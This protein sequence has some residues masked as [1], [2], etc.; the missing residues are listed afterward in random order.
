MRQEARAKLILQSM[1]A[2]KYDGMVVGERDLSLGLPFLLDAAKEAKVP[3]LSANLVDPG[4]K[5]LFTG[6]LAFQDGSLKV[7]VVALSPAGSYGATLT[8]QDPAQA[9]Q[10]ELQAVAGEGCAVKVLLANLPRS[11]L[12][13]T[14]KKV[15]G[16]D[17][18]ASAHDGWQA[19]PQLVSGVPTVYCGQRGRSVTRLDI[20]RNDGNGIFT[21]LGAIG[22]QLDEAKRIDKQIGDLQAQIAKAATPQLQTNFKTRLQAIEK[23][24]ED[25]AKTVPVGGEPPRSFRSTFFTLDTSVADDPDLKKLADA[26][27]AK[28]P[29]VVAAARPM[30]PR[31]PFGKPGVPGRSPLIPAPRPPP[32]VLA[33]PKPGPPSR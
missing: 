21:D 10:R 15:P 1:A 5:P 3:L 4:G 26:Y 23:R 25:I 22:R 29:D 31:P 32:P 8:H 18:V 12:E 17:L 19:E 13:D 14:L 11:E 20:V 2:M 28:Y 16:F 6:H 7:C 24:K 33:A 27:Q 9:A 30:A